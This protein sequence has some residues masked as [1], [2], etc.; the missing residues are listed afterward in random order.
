M[1]PPSPRRRWTA[2]GRPGPS[3]IRNLGD[4]LRQES[5]G[6]GFLLAGA[7][8]ALIWANSPWGGAYT[9]LAETVVGPRA[10]HL[11]LTVADWATD[12]LLT[13]FFFVVGLELKREMVVGQLRRLATAIVPVVAATGGMALPALI[14]WLVNTLRGS[15]AMSGWAIPVATDIAFAVAVLSA[16]GRGL[17]SALRAFL[18][19]LAVADDLLGIVV[20]AVF[21]SGGV[22][23]A[24]LAGSLG[25][26]AV[27][28][29]LVR[30]RRPWAWALFALALAAWY[31]MHRSGIHSTIA[32]VL[33][34]F[35]TPARPTPSQGQRS[36]PRTD[37]Y[38]HWW[39]PISAG[40]A[41]PVFALFAAGVHLS[42]A[43]LRAAALDPAAQGVVAGLIV[44]KPLGI[45][46]T[47]F[48]LVAL[49]RAAL[50][51][52]VRWP[53]IAAVGCVGGIGF[54][55][56]LLI[57]ELAFAAASPHE[58]AVKAAILFG[59]LGAAAIGAVLL[60]VRAR[61]HRRHRDLAWEAAEAV[62]EGDIDLAVAPD[63][64]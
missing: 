61:W 36:T 48:A 50:D 59:S 42:P 41:V 6:A 58:A 32:G 5:A 47:T 31:C 34:G 45:F 49:T 20:I 19:T 11:D 8:V 9:A 62:D 18:L 2:F 39:R 10:W 54:T 21:Y 37:H 56:S 14:Y 17:P 38:E 12:G 40:L 28:L 24:W 63:D 55:V 27:Y 23:V 33:L 51:P 44:G 3:T 7:V 16:F 53:D 57:G 22:S 52:A 30:R 26:V 43:D 29:L 60:A 1:T 13:V 64:E 25:A 35:A 15:Q 4:T 46:L